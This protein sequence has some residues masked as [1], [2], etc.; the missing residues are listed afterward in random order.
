M[1]VS[2]NLNPYEKVDIEWSD[3]FEEQLGEFI[4]LLKCEENDVATPEYSREIIKA[5]EEAIEQI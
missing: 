1:Y 4:K 2:K 3:V 5:L